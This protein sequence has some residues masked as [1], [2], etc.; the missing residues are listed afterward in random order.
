MKRNLLKILLLIPFLILIISLYNLSDLNKLDTYTA[1]FISIS[2]AI[3][4]FSISFSFLQYQFSPYKA[5]L[6]SISPRHLYYSYT[7]IFIALVPLTF[8]FVNKKHVALSCI[9]CIPLLAYG[10]ILLLIIANEET[11]PI[12]LLKRK[13]KRRK[14]RRFLNVYEHR[15]KNENEKNKTLDFSKPAERPMHDYAEKH[16]TAS[17]PGDPFFFIN[18]VIDLTLKNGDVY[19]YENAIDLFLNLVDTCINDEKA[20]YESGF[21]FKVDKLINDSFE[22]LVNTVSA[23]SNSMPVQNLL[24][25]KT[26]DFLKV[27]A[28]S[29]LQT[30]EPFSGMA[31][32]LTNYGKSVLVE[33]RDI[34]IYIISLFRQLAQKG[35]YSPPEDE[36]SRMFS[37]YLIVFP[38]Y[39][40]ILGQEAIKQQSSDF[41]FR[42]LEDLGFL[43]CTAIKANHYDVAIECLQGIVQLGREARAAK[44]KC[45]WRHC[46]LEPLDHADERIWWMLSWVPNLDEKE[47]ESWKDSF[48]AAYSRLHGKKIEISFAPKGDKI[49]VVFNRTEEPHTEGYIDR[50]Y[51]K[52]VDYSDTNEIKEFKMY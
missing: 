52:Q 31:S 27:K 30:R 51:S 10:A 49:A 38:N 42:C 48:G 40:K 50:T 29:H 26:C 28:L 32:M 3:A 44:L 34:A 1:S 2:L 47:R 15:V 25:S 36:E 6:K 17:I 22:V 37:H 13:T 12:I 24:V 35:I 20:T 46:A 45:F 23:K 7:L 33:N 21:R 39:I 43:G 18:Y 16:N 5:L 11:N 41:L 19:T 8:L 9:F 4:T 14:I